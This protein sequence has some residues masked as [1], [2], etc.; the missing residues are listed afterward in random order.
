MRMHKFT[1]AGAVLWQ[2]CEPSVDDVS[3]A[4]LDSSGRLVLCPFK[5]S[6]DDDDE[7]FGF[8]LLVEIT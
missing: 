1:A 3:D 2:C 6:V 8:F 7:H 5:P 4:M